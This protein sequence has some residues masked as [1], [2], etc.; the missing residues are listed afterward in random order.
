MATVMTDNFGGTL[1]SSFAGDAVY[2][3]VAG[4]AP[5]YV[6]DASYGQALQCPA[7]SQS[8]IAETFSGTTER[9]FDRIYQLSGAATTAGVVFDVRTSSSIAKGLFTASNKLQLQTGAGV[10]LATSTNSLPT[11]AKFRVVYT[12]NGT[13]WK[14]DLYANDTTVTILETITG[15]I[16]STSVTAARDGFSTATGVGTGVTLNMAWP[17][18]GDTTVPGPRPTVTAPG[19]PTGATATAG[20][21]QATVTWTAPSSNGNAPIISYTVT[22]TPGSF[23]ATWNGGPLTA[24]VNGLS[25]GTA[26][27]FAVTATNTFGTSSASSASNSVTPNVGIYAAQ[28]SNGAEGGTNG[29][30]ITTGNSG[31]TSGDPLTNIIIGSGAALVF[32]NA[33]HAHGSLS[34]GL[35]GASGT[36]SA[37]GWLGLSDTSIAARFYFNM[38]SATPGVQIR[39]MDIRSAGASA[40]K[41]V[42]GAS[43]KLSVQDSTGTNVYNFGTALSTST[44]YRIELAITVSASSAIIKSDYYAMDSTSPVE[45]GYS[46][47]TGNTASATI[48]TVNF[49]SA[50]ST[51]WTGTSYYDDLAVVNGTTTYVGPYQTPT[52]PAVPSGVSA[53]KGSGDA[54]VSFASSLSSG[55]SEI[56]GYTATSTPGS[57]TGSCSKTGTSITV[58]GLTNG[59]A[60]TFTVHATNSIG[61]SAESTASNSVT[62][63]NTTPV[64]NAGSDQSAVVGNVVMLDGS[65]SY[66]ADSG[67]TITYAWTHSSGPYGGSLSSATA[68]QPTYTTTG[69]GVD[70][71]SLVVT[72]NHGAASSADLV[73]VTVVTAPIMVR[74]SGGWS[75]AVTKIRRSG[76]WE[77]ID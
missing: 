55:G 30:T 18:D 75:P 37:F 17:E 40:A 33:S 13:V 57:I 27:T 60:Y 24:V 44:W 54:I 25:N 29:T 65:G 77:T 32:S 59:T 16:S 7:A 5:T 74:R 38:G 64:A 71:W 42:L 39:I 69:P 52:V 8:I 9:I 70:I 53:V 21:A 51:T 31:G 1:S 11:G 20:N 43:G 41:I 15:T 61:N 28:L 35:T 23:T 4:T 19:A 63:S 2:S 49:G 46:T 76:A 66:D 26:Y 36:A 10:T 14:A 72:D 34:Y 50:A 3:N 58:S 22:S 6:A 47:T 45:T 68:Q 73:S 67:D 56:T 62:P 48:T 12:I